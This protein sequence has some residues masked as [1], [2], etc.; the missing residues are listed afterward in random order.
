[1]RWSYVADLGKDGALDWGGNNT[2]NIPVTERY[3]P[4]FQDNVLYRTINWHAQQGNYEGR[5]VD[6]GASAIKVDGPQI[7]E[8]LAECYGD[9]EQRS[10]KSEIGMLATFAK[11]LPTGKQMAL[12]ACSM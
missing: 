7:L 9:L 2:G 10:A 8:I 1:M 3:L 4:N 5:A 12:I 6:W 11:N